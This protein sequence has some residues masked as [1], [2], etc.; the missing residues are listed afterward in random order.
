MTLAST[1]AGQNL[2][3]ISALAN[4]NT[5]QLQAGSI[6]LSMK[7]LCNQAHALT[8][9]SSNGGLKSQSPSNA[10]LGTGF[11]SRVDYVAQATWASNSVTLQTAGIIGQSAPPAQVTGAF[12]G[13]LILQI[14]IDPSGAGYLPLIAGGYTDTLTLTLAPQL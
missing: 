4:P 13:N 8:I 14:A 2:I 1:A 6:L 5:A 11:A 12:S 9:T 3:S 7:G 10:P